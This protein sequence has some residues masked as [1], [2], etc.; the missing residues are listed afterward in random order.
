MIT[1]ADTVLPPQEGSFVNIRD[2]NCKFCQQQNTN[3]KGHGK[4]S[5]NTREEI[6]KIQ[7]SLKSSSAE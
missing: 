1:R 5:A 2:N 6:I 7:Y 3:C 4:G